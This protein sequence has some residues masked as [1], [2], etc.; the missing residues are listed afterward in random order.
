MTVAER[1]ADTLARLALY[2]QV[3][4]EERKAGHPTLRDR[5]TVTMPEQGVYRVT[6]TDTGRHTDCEFMAE[7]RLLVEWVTA[8]DLPRRKAA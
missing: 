6:D 4:E 1:N 3:R 8:L 5:Y 7:A 2:E